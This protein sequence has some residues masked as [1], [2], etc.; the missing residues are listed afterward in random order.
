MLIIPLEGCGQRRT[1]EEPGVIEVMTGAQH[2]ETYKK[3]RSKL[4]DVNKSL[5]DRYRDID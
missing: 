1:P 4:Q 3:A 5:E 2:V